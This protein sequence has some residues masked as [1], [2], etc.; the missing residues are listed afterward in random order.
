MDTHRATRFNLEDNWIPCCHS[1]PASRSMR[2]ANRPTSFLVW[3]D[4]QIS[5][6]V[7]G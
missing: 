1:S 6:F 7:V 4:T 5:C 3:T 2:L